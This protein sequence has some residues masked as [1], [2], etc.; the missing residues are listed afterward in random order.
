MSKEFYYDC[1]KHDLTK[2]I[3]SKIKKL[4]RESTHKKGFEYF[5]SNCECIHK[6][7]ILKELKKDIKDM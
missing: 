1:F 4:E 3:D 6:I 7:V 5:W 2:I